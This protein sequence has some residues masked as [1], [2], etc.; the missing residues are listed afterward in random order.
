M[1]IVDD[2]LRVNGNVTV[3]GSLKPNRPRSELA[4][5][6]LMEYPV[7]LTDFRVHDALETVLPGTPA[8]DDLGITG[9]TYGTHAPKL[10]TGDLK[11]A[12]STTRRGRFTYELPPEYVAGETVTLRLSAGMETTVAD[13]AA[14]ID[15]ECFVNGRDGT[16]D[17]SD[18][19]TTA[20]TTINA[21]GF[22]NKDFTI[23]PTALVPGDQLD[24]RVSVLVN[25][26]ASAT[27]VIA[28]IGA[29]DL[30]LDIK[31]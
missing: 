22:S 25:D 11:A 17:G 6:S 23:T 18:L 3:T 16:V 4:Q 26:A 28:S 7:K 30:L 12:G 20:A 29:V 2:D 24:I 15:A 5:E 19:V 10:T 1:N 14:T 27:A 31:G 8:S 13:V 9:G 21:L